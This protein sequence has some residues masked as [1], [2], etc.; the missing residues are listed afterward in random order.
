M[1]LLLA[2]FTAFLF[3][4]LYPQVSQMENIAT[5]DSLRR[6]CVESQLKFHLS[7]IVPAVISFHSMSNG[8]LVFYPSTRLCSSPVFSPFQMSRLLSPFLLE[9]E[10]R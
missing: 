6:P 10:I 3:P 8:L 2:N 5:I 7:I 1:Y 4:P 9:E